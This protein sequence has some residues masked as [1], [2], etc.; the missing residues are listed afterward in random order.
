VV[1]VTRHRKDGEQANRARAKAH[2]FYQRLMTEIFREA[3]RVLRDDG[4]LTIM[5]THKQSSAWANMFRALIQAGFTITATWSVRTES[6]HSLHQ[7]GRKSAQATNLLVA[8]K[9]EEQMEDIGSFEAMID[10]ILRAARETFMRLESD[11]FGPVDQVVGSFG[12]ALKSFLR[13]KEV[14]KASGERVDVA[15]AIQIVERAVLAWQKEREER[16]RLDFM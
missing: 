3:H 7:M 9:R 16:G 15:E 11:G 4:V 6:P 14:Y 2:E 1:N 12:P 10:E 5:F 13:Y 8:R